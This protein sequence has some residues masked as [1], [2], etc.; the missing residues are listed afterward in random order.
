VAAIA[1]RLDQ[2]LMDAGIG[3]GV[4]VGLIGRNRPASS[5]AMIGLLAT[6]RCVAPLNPFQSADRLAEE[7]ARL[8]VAAVVGEHEDFEGDALRRAATQ[9]GF[10]TVALESEEP[11]GVRLIDQPSKKELTATGSWALLLST[12]GTTGTPKRIPIRFD[13]LEASLADSRLVGMEFGDLDL[14]G[15]QQ[16]PLI[17]HSPMVH[18]AGALSV[19]RAGYDR[20]RLVMLQKFSAAAWVD[21]VERHGPRAASLPPTMMRAVVNEN[22]RAEALASIRGVWSGASPIDMKILRMFEDRYGPVVM[23]SYGA[24]EYAGM[25]ASGSLAARQQWGHAKDHSCGHIRAH[26][27]RVRIV[28]SDGAE[29]PLGK[30]GVLEVQVYRIGP[31]WMR[32]SD[33]ASVDAD[34]FLYFHGR[35]DDAINRGGFKIVPSVIADA[36]RR[37]PA[38]GDVAVVAL[39]DERLGEVPVAA[40]ELR[41][42]AAALEGDAL[43]DFAR[44]ELVAYQV[45][46]EIKV[47]KTLPRTP[48]FKVDRKALL[49]LFTSTTG[50]ED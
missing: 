5:S 11:E 49:A 50:G 31:D 10:A 28:D 16:T 24:T 15:S 2:L 39:P 12:S 45:P 22:P 35:A 25:I 37:H 36:L 8:N 48:S 29:M 44:A 14:P 43:L 1:S 26:V 33:L 32:T 21:A 6:G 34:N 19:A 47:V 4:A 41:P 23:G 30:V 38:V 40:V 13:S 7:A 42:G 17:Q 9:D 46:T 18:V 3:P 27:A 20:R